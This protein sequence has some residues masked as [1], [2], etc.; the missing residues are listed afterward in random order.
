[1]HVVSTSEQ[2]KKIEAVGVDAIIAEGGESG[3]LVSKN[4]I[5]TLVLVPLVVDAVR[6]PVVAA[7]GIGDARG[8]VACMALGA[9]G[10]QLGTIFEASEESSAS[11]EW[12]AG[13]IKARETDTI[14]TSNGGINA[15]VVKE[16]IYPGGIMTG[17]IAGMV[18]KIEKSADIIA[19]IVADIDGIYNTI[20]AQIR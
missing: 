15:R 12:K 19:R 13:I 2:A 6:M 9:Q 11:G 16:E 14:V 10:V 8:L 20:G 18:Q 4:I 7:G 1:M 3:G 17:Q 5:S